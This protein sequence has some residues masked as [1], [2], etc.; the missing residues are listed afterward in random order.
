M[1]EVACYELVIERLGLVPYAEAHVLQ[2][3]VHA[4]VAAG[5]RSPTLL[6]LEHPRTITLGYSA[7]REHLLFSEAYYAQHGIAVHATERGGNATYHGPGQLVGYP[8]VPVQSR[9]ADY[10]RQL[11]TILL[12][13]LAGYGIQGRGNPGYAGIMV[14]VP[15]DRTAKLA[16]IGIAV[17]KRVAFHGFALNVSPDLRDFDLIVPCGMQGQAITSLQQLLGDAPSMDDVTGRVAAAFLRH[18]PRMVA[19]S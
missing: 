19:D 17:R 6:L 5:T 8:I 9:V 1:S 7:K 2:K 15:N 11:E 12:E 4:D 13:V 3:Q 14:D 16:A 10:L 18:W